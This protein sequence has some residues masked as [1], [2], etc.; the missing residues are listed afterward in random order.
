MRG[1]LVAAMALAITGCATKQY[2]RLQPVSAFEMSSYSC[3]DIA[4]E[5]SKVEAFD[6]QIR[7]QSGFD[8]RSALGVLGDFGLGN[9]MAKGS[10]EKSA[11][12]RRRQLAMLGAQKGCN[13]PP[14][15]VTPVAAAP[16][17]TAK[18]P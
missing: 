5:L 9:S 1:I 10:A 3:R 8:G 15:E 17:E 2:G 6:E 12:E 4:I 18:A 13:P 11:I 7:E 14:P 16:A